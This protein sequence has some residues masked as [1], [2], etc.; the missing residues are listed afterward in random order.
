MYSSDFLLV[1]WFR[2]IF[3]LYACRGLSDQFI[4][5][6]STKVIRC[7]CMGIC[8]LK[9]L[10]VHPKNYLALCKCYGVCIILATVTSYGSQCSKRLSTTVFYCECRKANKTILQYSFVEGDREGGDVRG[11]GGWS[12]N[13]FWLVTCACIV[14]IILYTLSCNSKQWFSGLCQIVFS[15]ALLPE[16]L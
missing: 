5:S 4:Q 1:W 10:Y 7:Q 2:L 11:R 14:V 8:D 3:S 16:S 15:R 13:T 9:E 6:I 12:L